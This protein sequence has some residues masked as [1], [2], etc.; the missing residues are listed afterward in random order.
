[1]TNEERA[2][3]AVKKMKATIMWDDAHMII[4]AALNAATAELEAE[5]VRLREAL[6]EAEEVL[7]LS[8]RPAL[9]DPRYGDMI[10]DLGNQIGFGAIMSAASH[11]WR[12]VL[13]E[14]W[15]DYG[16]E[17][18]EHVSG[19]SHRTVLATLKK[20]RSALTKKDPSNG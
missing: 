18:S 14:E 16:L 5:R 1:M 2:R 20:I 11:E 13:K 12:Q 9:K 7:A 17:G 4:L 10:R 19:P 15:A 6:D 3:E 8:E